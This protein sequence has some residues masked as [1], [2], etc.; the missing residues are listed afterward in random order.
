MS[1]PSRRVVVTGYGA[2]TPLGSSMEQSWD[3]IMAGKIGYQRIDRQAAGI[4]SHFYGLA[5]AKPDIAFLPAAIRRRLPRF[6]QLALVSAREAM[7][8]AFGERPVTEMY[9]P[10]ACGAIIGTGWAGL[11]EALENYDQYQQTGMGS[12]FGC[13][14][15]MPNVAT[16]ACSQFWGLR[17]YQNTPVA[18]CATGTIAIGDAFEV[19][20]SGRADMMLAGGAESLTK[21]NSIWNIDVLKA[22]TPEQHDP[23]LACCPFSLDRNGFVLSE[24][25]AVLCLEERG[26]ALA[27]GAA[28]LGEITGYGNY[29]DA[30]NFT[31]PAADKIP[32]TKAIR[33]ALAQAGLAPEELGY[34]NAHGTS[35][36]VGDV[37]ELGAIR[38]VF[39]DNTPAI[40]ATK[41]MTG[42]SLGAA[43]VQEAIYTLLMLEHGFIAPS[44]NIET[45]DP[46]AE[47][48]NIVTKPTEKALTTVM[49]NSFGFGGTNATLTMRK[50]QA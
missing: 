16:A 20:R 43:G 19:I 47:G 14:L 15:T 21:D 49:S 17:G 1:T 3:A 31:A 22:L 12:M 42:H 36:P 13:F 27:R 5:T 2:V 40:S 23:A 33:A 37:K 24:G 38:E 48:M 50:F 30:V 6:A 29:S 9:D 44:I 32:R 8:M 39:G 34:I 35:T 28:I 41:A 4:A 18:A 45:P 11:D 10:L 46:A 25:G 7:V 26:A